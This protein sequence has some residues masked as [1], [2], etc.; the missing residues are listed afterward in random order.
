MNLVLINSFRSEWLKKRRS[1]ASWLV[2][3]GGLF[4]PGI[5]IAARLVRHDRLQEIYA[6]AN[7]WN[8]LWKSSWESMAI[9]FLPMG[10]IL[11][12]S[13]MTQ[14]EFKNNAWKQVH[15]LPLSLATIYCSK[16]AVI[17]VMMAQFLVIFDLGIYLSAVVPCW[18]I[19]GVPYPSTPIPY[20][21]FLKES[22]L[23]FCDSL[24]IVALQ[25]LI[26]LRFK[27]F[28]VPVGAGFVLWVGAL[29]ALPWKYGFLVPYSYCMIHYLEGAPAGKVADPAVNIHAMALGYFLLLT[30]V[31]YGL[32]ATKK[33]KG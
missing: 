20:Q 22:A 24:P 5:V 17:L 31:G 13:L 2:V 33:E 9:F 21:Y 32:F 25:Y 29:S 27:N 28:L 18:L 7:F 23:F 6:A 15:A 10:A 14:I 3:V 8:S 30:A 19:G 26:S 4:T 11:A 12:T 1:L 16:L